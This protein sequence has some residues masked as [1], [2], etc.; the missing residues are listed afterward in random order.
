MIKEEEERKKFLAQPATMDKAMILTLQKMYNDIFIELYQE[1]QQLDKD[2]KEEMF[3]LMY[4][5][6]NDVFWEKSGQIDPDEVQANI[7]KLDLN[8]D[9]DFK[10]LKIHSWI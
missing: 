8:N 6:N 9:S 5:K 1:Y 7:Q 10:N 2:K 4:H 3:K